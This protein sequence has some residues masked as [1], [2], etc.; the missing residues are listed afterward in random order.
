MCLSHT[1]DVQ[2]ELDSTQRQAHA[3]EARA[4]AAEAQLV[5]LKQVHAHKLVTIIRWSTQFEVSSLVPYKP[6]ADWKTLQLGLSAPLLLVVLCIHETLRLVTVQD[7]MNKPAERSFVFLAL[8][9]RKQ[10]HDHSTDM[11][12]SK[13]QVCS[14]EHELQLD[15]LSVARRKRAGSFGTGQGAASAPAHRS[16]AFTNAASG[17]A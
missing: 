13:T 8:G 17:P 5:T 3:A 1:A 12:C 2:E 16:S 9:D 11:C 6:H 7:A 4:A 10:G 15:V 14:K